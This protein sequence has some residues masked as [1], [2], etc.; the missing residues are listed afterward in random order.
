MAVDNAQ[1]VATQLE[2]VRS[3]IPRLFDRDVTFYSNIDKKDKEVVSSREMRIPLEIR[4][5]GKFGHFN[6]DGGDM[7][8]GD[9]PTWDKAVISTED[10]RHAVEWNTKTKWAT[11]KKRKAVINATQQLLAKSM[12]EFRRHVDSLCM[13]SGDAVLATVSAISTANSKNT[14][15]CNDDN[16]DIRLLR[17]GQKIGAIS[18]NLATARA[19]SAKD[20]YL[21]IEK[22][23]R[24]NRQI[25]VDGEFTSLAVGDKLVLEGKRQANPTSI[26]GV[27]Y[28]HNNSSTGSWLGFTRSSTPE[29]RS[30]RVNAAGSLALSHARLA[31]NKIGDRIGMDQ[32]NMRCYAWMHHAQQHAYEELGQL[33]SIINKVPKQEGLNLY[34][35][36]NMQMAGAPVKVSYSWDRQRIDFVNYDVWGRSEMKEPDFYEIDG[37]KVFP[38]YGS[39]GG[40]A[41]AYIF[42]IVASFNLFVD[43][44]AGTSYI[45]GLTV[46]SGY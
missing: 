17:F 38:L 39:S 42:Y 13:T 28:H 45:D 46:P 34:F 31:K 35:G 15:T 29:I 19:S 21:N 32:A 36:D 6:P 9:G 43:N 18:S 3:K 10:L 33:V 22:Y 5:G 20:N 4:P 44:P 1:V 7:G 40:L 14:I 24:D 41:A 16:F 25:V 2:R 26:L 11:D 23:D 37:K 27:K 8:R 12:A 30:N